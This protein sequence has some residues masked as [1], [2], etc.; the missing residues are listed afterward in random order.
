M[1]GNATVQSMNQYDEIYSLS[2]GERSD[3]QI[4]RAD[5]G[6]ELLFLK[7][8]DTRKGIKGFFH[9]HHNATTAL[10]CIRSIPAD[11]R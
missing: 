11:A 2:M 5:D 3:V 10:S 1:T 4:K 6:V 8:T 9:P 7:I